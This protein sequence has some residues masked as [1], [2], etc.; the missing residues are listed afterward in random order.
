MLS[1]TS[2]YDGKFVLL[3]SEARE[4]WDRPNAVILEL[5]SE[6]PPQPLVQHTMWSWRS[7][8][9]LLHTMS[10]TCSAATSPL[11]IQLSLSTQL[12]DISASISPFAST[13]VNPRTSPPIRQP[14]LPS[15][16]ASQSIHNP[17][18]LHSNLVI[19]S[20]P[21]TTSSISHIS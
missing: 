6:F 3:Q 20:P 4:W 10:R 12:T 11:N 18:N 16:P 2:R 8:E 5:Y 17:T 14:G 19:Y 13:P 21:F 1:C 9:T 15:S 7:G